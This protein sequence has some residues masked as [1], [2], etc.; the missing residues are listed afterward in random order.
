MKAAEEGC[1]EVMKLLINANVDLEA[2]NKKGRSALSFAAAPSGNREVR[3]DAVRYLLETGADPLRRDDDDLTAK[4]RAAQ[5][6]RRRKLLNVNDVV[7][8]LELYESKKES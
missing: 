2:V 6:G 1:V 3:L 8:L 5:E 4:M 7:A